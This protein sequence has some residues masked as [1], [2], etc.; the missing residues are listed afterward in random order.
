MNFDVFKSPLAGIREDA[1]LDGNVA[2]VSIAASGKK[3]K[4]RVETL[5]KFLKL[6]KFA[7]I[8]S[9]E[10]VQRGKRISRH[11]FSPLRLW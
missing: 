8:S 9:I 6:S 10:K 4:E 7:R 11:F 2:R 3:R 1:R 5:I